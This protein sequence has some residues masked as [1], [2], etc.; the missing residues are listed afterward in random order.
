MS[1]RTKTLSI[2]VISVGLTLVVLYGLSRVILMEGYELLELDHVNRNLRRVHLAISS[3]FEHLR[4][5]GIDWAHWDDTYVFVQDRNEGYIESNILDSVFE[6]YTLEF[7]VFVDTAGEVVYSQGYDLDTS[8]RIDVSPALLAS[9]TQNDWL[10]RPANEHGELLTDGVA[11]IISVTAG[12]GRT[13]SVMLASVPIL[14]SIEEGTSAGGLIWGRYIT[15]AISET[16]SQQT[17]VKASLH[18]LETTETTDQNLPPEIISQLRSQPDSEMVLEYVSEATLAGHSILND[19]QGNPALAIRAEID[20][21]IYQQ[22]QANIGFFVLAMSVIGTSAVTVFT[23]VLEKRVLSRLAYL[24]SLVSSIQQT[25]DITSRVELDENDELTNLSHK[26]NE[27]LDS[28]QTQ[29]KMKLARDNAIKAAQLK[30][31]ILANVSHDARTPLT[32]ILMRSEML[33]N[34]IYGP[35]TSKQTEVLQNITTSSQQL[36]NFVNN[37]LEGAQIES[38]QLR[39]DIGEVVP[40][41]LLETIRTTLEPL[42]ARKHLRLETE[43]KDNLPEVFYGDEKRLER[44]LTN[45]VTNAIKFTDSGSVRVK[46]SGVRLSDSREDCLPE[47]CDHWVLEVTDTGPGIP[48]EYRQQIFTSFWQID[49]SKTRSANSGV[50]LGLSIV[51]QMVTLMGGTTTVQSIMGAGSTFTVILPVTTP[52]QQPEKGNEH[53]ETAL[54]LCH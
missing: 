15:A 32:V 31:E 11:G 38:G 53:A 41:R 42:A 50:G 23:I 9:V 27:M 44:V 19:L 29:E 13:S 47:D 6:D 43:L 28:L 40:H 33:L 37:M 17:V 10:T 34:G 1:L 5:T 20:R 51:Y 3:Q 22:G 2:L 4:T 39:L 35:L 54:D 45:L 8:E 12:D 16:I 25:G 30:A 26:I 24:S 18:P 52:V 36:L 14:P 7:M 49:G 21:T 48:E 46:I